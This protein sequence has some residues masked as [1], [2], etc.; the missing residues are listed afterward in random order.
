MKVFKRMKNKKI[1]AKW[2]LGI[3]TACL[4]YRED[5]VDFLEYESRLKT[6]S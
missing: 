3:F 2:E 1:K 6:N 5:N 4:N